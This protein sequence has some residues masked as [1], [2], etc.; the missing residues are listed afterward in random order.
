MICAI[1][2]RNDAHLSCSSSFDGFRLIYSERHISK[3]K[4]NIIMSRSKIRVS[5]VNKCS[6]IHKDV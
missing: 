4:N 5:Y 1:T 2:S 6:T 3:K